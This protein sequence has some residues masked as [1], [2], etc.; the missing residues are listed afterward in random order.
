MPKV[1]LTLREEIARRLR[2]D[3]VDGSL[4]P[5]AIIRDQELALR[6]ATSTSP[7]REAIMQLTAERLIETPSHR[8]KRVAPL[9]RQTSKDLF[10]VIRVLSLHCYEVGIPRL[11]AAA[12]RALRSNATAQRA[13]LTA[14]DHKRLARLLWDFHTPVYEAAGNREMSRVIADSFP[15]MHRLSTLMPLGAE[16]KVERERTLLAAFERRDADKAM[17]IF[18]L[19]ADEFDVNLD[20]LPNF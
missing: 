6:Y 2:A 4:R 12:L 5:G 19:W 14:N 13:A 10:E 11:D 8:V 15:W 16:T 3:V 9:D 1:G 18:R 7:V 17:K 20:R